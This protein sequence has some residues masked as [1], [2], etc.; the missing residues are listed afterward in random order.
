MNIQEYIKSYIDSSFSEVLPFPVVDKVFPKDHILHYPGEVEQHVYYLTQ[1]IVEICI[2][3]NEKESI[4]EFIFP[5]SFFCAYASLLTQLPADTRIQCLTDCTI[6]VLKRYDI[7]EAYQHSLVSN[8]L[9][10]Y[11]TEQLYLKRFGREKQ[12]LTMDA[13]ARYLE[14]ITKRPEIVEKIPLYKIANYLGIHP[15]SLSRI[16]KKIT[17]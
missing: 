1:G 8:K 14:L 2:V 11:V 16:R 6:S 9:G 5:D 17:S 4:L 15:E 3:N 12:L 7:M 10:R 13:Q